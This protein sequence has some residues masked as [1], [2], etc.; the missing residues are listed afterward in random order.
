MGLSSM[1]GL[2]L[3]L[4]IHP[5]TFREDKDKAKEANEAAWAAIVHNETSYNLTFLG[6]AFAASSVIVLW[7]CRSMEVLAFDAKS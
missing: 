5:S 2:E 4:F 3:Q 1:A 6:I 7:S